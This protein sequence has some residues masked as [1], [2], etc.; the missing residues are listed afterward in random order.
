MCP[1]SLH[2]NAPISHLESNVVM[3]RCWGDSGRD[4]M[5]G[6]KKEQIFLIFNILL[7]KIFMI[8]NCIQFSVIKHT[9]KRKQDIKWQTDG[10]PRLP[11]NGPQLSIG[12]V[13]WWACHWSNRNFGGGSFHQVTQPNWAMSKETLCYKKGQ[14]GVTQDQ[15]KLLHHPYHSL[16][17]QSRGW[18]K[19]GVSLRPSG[20][21]PQGPSTTSNLPSPAWLQGTAQ[22]NGRPKPAASL[23]V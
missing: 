4:G 1:S 13:N 20:G 21:L 14:E 19:A 23:E 17:Y 12:L 6:A 16:N 3:E 5:T 8:I 10:P 7:I 15:E 2:T 9:I 22:G 11:R 18:L